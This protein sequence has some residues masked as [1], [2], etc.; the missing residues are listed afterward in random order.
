MNFLLHC[1]GCH[2]S[3]GTG[4][5]GVVPNLGDYLGVFAQD[6]DARSFPARVPGASSAPIS[7]DDLAEVL[8]WILITMNRS[9]LH[10]DFAPY[11]GA[12]VGRYRRHPLVDVLTVRDRLIERIHGTD[13][14]HGATSP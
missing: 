1:A 2:Q 9:Q 3:D 6:K 12:E 7:D 13:T 11:T 14:G 4:A 5:P 10:D 8:N